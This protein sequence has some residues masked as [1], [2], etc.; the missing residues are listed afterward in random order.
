MDTDHQDDAYPCWL[1][2]T[3]TNS[4]NYF[5]L[6]EPTNAAEDDSVFGVSVRGFDGISS[7]FM[8]RKKKKKNNEN[9][10][11]DTESPILLDQLLVI[12]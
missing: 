3:D 7:D 9:I 6:N 10:G 11:F 1:T 8:W 12:Q 4:K 2:A 5:I